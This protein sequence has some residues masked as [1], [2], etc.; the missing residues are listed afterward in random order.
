[1]SLLRGRGY[2]DPPGALSRQVSSQQPGL[3]KWQPHH[4]AHPL[5]TRSSASQCTS[6]APPPFEPPAQVA[7]NKIWS[8]HCIKE[9]GL[10]VLNTTFAINNTDKMS[11]LPEK[12]NYMV[13]H[14]RMSNHEVEKAKG[15]IRDVCSIKDMDLPPQERFE[16]PLTSSQEYGWHHKPMVPPNPMFYFTKGGCDITQYADSYVQM[17]GTTPFSRKIDS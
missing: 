17:K 4:Y 16:A 8:E 5:R 15:T 14:A 7:K 11:L 9:N 6:D 3:V 1:M 12:P 10:S 13:P 2:W